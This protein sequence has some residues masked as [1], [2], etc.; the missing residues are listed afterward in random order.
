MP[1]LACVGMAH[2]VPAAGLANTG[3]TVNQ[4]S[5]QDLETVA[6]N[7]QKLAGESQPHAHPH[8]HP[9]VPL[10]H[11]PR[12][13]VQH[14]YIEY[15]CAHNHIRRVCCSCQVGVIFSLRAVCQVGLSANA[16]SVLC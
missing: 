12:Q 4:L 1:L 2:P 11:L 3:C 10:F 5:T 7:H 9:H 13:V 8:P 16:D 15:E 6:D 14:T